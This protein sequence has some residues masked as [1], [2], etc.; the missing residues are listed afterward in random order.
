[1]KTVLLREIAHT[2]AGEKINH[3]NCSVIAYRDEDYAL[4]CRE[5]TVEHVLSVFGKIA[6]GRVT[7]YE[8]PNISALNFV[9]E[10][11]LEGGRT[12]TLSFE[13]SGKALSSLMLSLPVSVPD[14]FVPRCEDV[15]NGRAE[16]PY[17]P[18]YEPKAAG[19]RVRIGAATAWAR[20]RFDVPE[21]LVKNGDL[22]YI[23]FE[24]MSE[25]TQSAAQ[26]KKVGA[27][28]GVDYDPYLER[29]IGAVLSD[30]VKKGIKIISNQGWIDPM[31][32]A[33]KIAEMAKER[34]ISGL[35][36][37]AVSG[38]V[39][40][41]KILELGGVF[42][43]NGRNVAEYKDQLISAEVYLGV[44]GVLE[45]LRNGADV[46]VTSRIVDSALYCGPLAYEFGWDLNDLALCA[47]GSTIG[48]LME[49][50]PQISGGYFMDPG[51]KDVPD[52][53]HLG[54]PIAEVTADHVYIT[55]TQTR[56]GCVT[57]R[58][59]KEQLL[60][61]IGNPDA[62]LLPNVTLSFM[63][64]K[65]RQVAKDVVE[66]TGF[67]GY[68]KPATF[69]VLAG[70]REGF[71]TEAMVL[72]A[73]PGAFDRAEADKRIILTRMQE[74]GFDMDQLRID[75]VGINSI[76]REATPQTDALPYEAIL[77]IAARGDSV[78]ECLKLK[79]EIDA[80]AVCGPS[81]TGKWGTMGTSIRPIVGFFSMLVDPKQCPYS[82]SYVEI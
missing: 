18:A 1:M 45:A 66:V 80:Q 21:D 73:G 17:V 27:A 36:I 28:G 59:C 61:E 78:K 34:G 40:N 43:D 67:K 14:D 63:D 10:N 72:F 25:V 64:L 53:E 5:V 46:V 57:P 41:E 26:V 69:K 49:C 3:L 65:F 42:Q 20:D 47:K 15:K 76:H 7:R 24:A 12:R 30:C 32:A 68:E 56:G 11:I 6:K 44:D 75:Y 33:E 62:Y 23:C 58:T 13:E 31:G 2:R 55:K 22:D 70:V 82:V 77:R 50:G 19:K 29:R 39:L 60:Y 8:M 48:H 81:G 51:Y 4:L 38:S 74:A 71:M 16:A 79:E 54:L 37:A 35:K 52:I 9:F